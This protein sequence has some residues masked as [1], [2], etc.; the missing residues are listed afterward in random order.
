MPP[1][2]KHFRKWLKQR[3][4]TSHTLHYVLSHIGALVMRGLYYSCRV[5]RQFAPELAAYHRGEKRAIF[6]FWHGRMI[7]MPFLKPP[8]ECAVLISHHAD[9]SLITTTMERF[10]IGAVRGSKSQGSSEAV[11]ALVDAAARGLNLAITP[12]GPRGP[13]QIARPAR[14]MSPCARATPSSRWRFPPPGIGACRA[15]TVS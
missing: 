3:L 7:M 8:G 4:K 13:F 2:K 11:R 10:G 6:V 15:G 9:G 12:D 14:C 5:E 1:V